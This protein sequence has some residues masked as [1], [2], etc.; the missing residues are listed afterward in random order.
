[1]VFPALTIERGVF[2]VGVRGVFD[3]HQT[4]EMGDI[5]A[6]NVVI[7]DMTYGLGANNNEG[8]ELD[9]VTVDG[10]ST[11]LTFSASRVSMH[12]IWVANSTYA[13]DMIAS[14]LSAERMSIEG[15]RFFGVRVNGPSASATISDA[16]MTARPG[17]LCGITAVDRAHLRVRRTRF[18][19]PSYA[20]IID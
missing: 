1:E 18:A 2:E 16:T 20:V 10:T 9:H 19:T 13:V 3:V 8:V 7:R 14:R 17:G 12:D 11:G 4:G 6:S 5:V 15:A